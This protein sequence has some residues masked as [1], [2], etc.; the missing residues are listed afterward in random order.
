MAAIIAI[1]RAM[2]RGCNQ[3]QHTQAAGSFSTSE[4]QMERQRKEQE[5]NI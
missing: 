5:T 1:S 3:T 4:T 2:L